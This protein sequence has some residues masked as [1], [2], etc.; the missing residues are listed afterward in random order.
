MFRQKYLKYKKKYLRLKSR[1]I[2][3][4][5]EERKRIV[6]AMVEDLMQNPTFKDNSGEERIIKVAEKIKSSEIRPITDVSEVSDVIIEYL[7]QH[8]ILQ[9]YSD[10]DYP[11]TPHEILQ[12]IVEWEHV[13]RESELVD[14]Q[15]VNLREI[16]GPYIETKEDIEVAFLDELEDYVSFRH[17]MVRILAGLLR[18]D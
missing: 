16:S 3:G 5:V 12:K 10:P 2:G 4:T 15:G 7:N 18:Q 6:R 8:D 9:D 14:S 13:P 17:L 1:Q 11:D